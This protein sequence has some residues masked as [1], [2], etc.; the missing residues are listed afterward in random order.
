MTRRRAEG[1]VAAAVCVA[2]VS[3]G[4]APQAP[5]PAAVLESAF[6]ADDFDLSTDPERPEWRDAPRVH[7][8]V[9][10]KGQ[11]VPGAPMEVRS[12][13]TR[14][15]LYLLFICPYDE[16]TLKPDPTPAIETPRLWNWD[17]AEAFIGSDFDRIGFYK[18]F[19]VSPQAEWVDL[20]I[21]RDNPKMQGGMAWNSRYTV[22]ARIDAAARVWYGAM[23]IPFGAIDTR[24][25]S[26]GR[27]LRI[28]LFR[29]AGPL[30][31]RV[32]YVWRPSGQPNFHVP[33]AFGTLR[34]R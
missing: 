18:E 17:V 3:L 10:Y 4:G 20:A 8:G 26:K 25:P 7:A 27:E 31:A 28:G 2:V 9:G 23:K 33:Q 34:L 30:S 11:P 13:W 1:L 5:D 15:Y 29:L 16:L 24:L 14:A 32:Q 6:A 22:A 19:Q 21:D 12:R